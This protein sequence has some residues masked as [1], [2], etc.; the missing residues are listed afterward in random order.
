MPFDVAYSTGAV[1]A[2]ATAAPAAD[3]NGMF[4]DDGLTFGDVLDVINPLQHIPVVSAIYRD[5]TGDTISPAA[6]IAGGGLFGGIFGLFA[7]VANVAVEQQ[8]GQDVGSHMGAMFDGDPPAD[9]ATRLADA[10]P[11]ESGAASGSTNSG[12]ATAAYTRT[13]Q[14]REPEFSRQGGP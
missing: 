2:G 13:A 7:A 3:G 8:T 14:L 12:E 4:G 10:T 6:R 1:P 5:L 11:A 9:G